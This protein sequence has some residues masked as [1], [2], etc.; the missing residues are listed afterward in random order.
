MTQRHQ[1]EPKFELTVEKITEKGIAVEKNKGRSKWS[2]RTKAGG[3][4][5]SCRL[6]RFLGRAVGECLHV[7]SLSARPW[8]NELAWC[9]CWLGLARLA[10]C[11]SGWDSLTC[12]SWDQLG[13]EQVLG[14]A[15]LCVGYVNV[16]AL[17][18]MS[19]FLAKLIILP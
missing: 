13:L 1:L 18:F 19:L 11:L 17:I 5:A 10:A 2:S 6:D 7:L 8:A 9:G 14:V 4:R 3:G 12:F 15:S 16:I